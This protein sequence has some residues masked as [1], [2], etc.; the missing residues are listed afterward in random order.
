MRCLRETCV[1]EAAS[2]SNYCDEHK[3][4]PDI[5]M[6][7]AGNLS[8]NDL[9]QR[10]V[11]EEQQKLSAVLKIE[12]ADDHNLV[13]FENIEPQNLSPII[14][15]EVKAG[16]SANALKAQQL[17]LGNVFIF[18][19]YVLVDNKKTEIMLF[20]SRVNVGL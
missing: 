8:L 19:G 7:F 3:F 12:K 9:A 2:G 16:D 15:I 4:F 20:R 13:Y 11:V 5:V 17:A 14:L 10:L 6:K 1:R 18:Q